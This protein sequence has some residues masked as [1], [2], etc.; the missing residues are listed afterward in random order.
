[1]RERHENVAWDVLKFPGNITFPPTAQY[2]FAQL[3]ES[4][5]W[6]WLN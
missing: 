4:I 5:I 2:R 3:T 1:M 6:D